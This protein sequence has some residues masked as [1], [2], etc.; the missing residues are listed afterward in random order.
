[1]VVTIVEGLG[2]TRHAQTAG[3]REG[4]KEE[5]GNGRRSEVVPLPLPL[6]LPL[7]PSRMTQT[8]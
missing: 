5:E 7:P 6:P 3:R 2:W 4:R 1:V 8:G